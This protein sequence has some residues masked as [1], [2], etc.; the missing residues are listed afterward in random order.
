MPAP[1]GVASQEPGLLSSTRSTIAPDALDAATTA[2]TARPKNAGYV[3][4]AATNRSSFG[5]TPLAGFVAIILVSLVALVT[6]LFAH[7]ASPPR[8]PPGSLPPDA[9]GGGAGACRQSWMSPS[10]LHISGTSLPLFRL[11]S[12]RVPEAHARFFVPRSPSPSPAP[13]P[14]STAFGR[15]YSRLG[16]GPWGLY[17]Y[18]EEGWDDDPFEP[19]VGHGA[20]STDPTP[21]AF[22]LT[23]IPVIFVPGNAGS[24]RQ[25]RSLASA[26][27]RAYYELPGV[28]RK[29]IGSKEGGR[30]LDF[31]TLDF[32]DDFSA[33]HGQ[34]L[35]DQAEY[36]AD[37]IRYIL[38]LY[39]QESNAIQG[40]PDPTSVIVIGHSMGGIVARAALL[41][42]HYQSGSISTLVTIAT[43]HAVPPVTVDRGVDRVYDNI[44]SYW[45]RAHHL[46]AMSSP[47]SRRDLRGEAELSNLV[48]VSISGGI[49][50][51]TVASES[52]SLTSIMP[53]NDSHG[54]TVFTTAI[55]GVQTPIDHLAMLWCRQLVETVAT[56][57]LAIV[58]VRSP[59]GVLPR[60]ARVGK[61]AER[62]L[63]AIESH[64]VK[65]EGRKSTLE[66]L[67]RGQHGRE[68]A[69]G[70]RLSL[71]GHGDKRSTFVLPIPPRR[72]YGS[73]RVFSL[74]TSANIGRSLDSL[75]E[76]YAC[77]KNESAP[78]STRSSSCTSLFPSFVTTIPISPHSAQSPILPAPAEDGT[79]AFLNVDVSQLESQD[80]IVVVV[81]PGNAWLLAEFGDKDRRIHTVDKSA[82]Q[83]MLGGF[84]IENFPTTPSLISELWLPALDSSL[85]TFKMKVFRS[86][87][88][89]EHREY[90]MPAYFYHL[91]A[92]DPIRTLADS[93]T[94]LFAPLLRQYSSLLHESKY[95]PNVREAS[96]Y[97]HASGPYLPAPASPFVSSGARLQL[98]VDPT[99]ARE[100]S[101]A[102]ADVAIEIKLDLWASLGNLAMRYR[103]AVVAFPFALILLVFACQLRDYN[104]GHSF[105]PFA[106]A[107]GTFARHHLMPLLGGLVALS[108]LQSVMLGT[109]LSFVE[110]KLAS[111]DAHFLPS[112]PPR[113]ISEMLLGNQ[114]PFFAFLGAFILFTM[115]S[116]VVLEYAAL[117]LL[118]T[119]LARLVRL[120]RQRG[121]S[122][123]RSF[124]TLVEPRE[125]LP[126]QRIVTMGALGLLV[127]FFA[128]Y[129]FAFLV[130]FLVHLLS[131][132][133]ALLLAQDASAPS[134]PASTRRLWDRYH[135]SFVSLLV[136]IGL[137]PINAMILAVWVRNLAVGWLA[138]F[139]TDHNVLNILGFLLNV[140]AL[141]SGKML[142]RTPGPTAS[143]VSIALPLIAAGFA[144]LYG[145]R[146]TY[147][148]YPLANAFFLW[149]SSNH[150][151]HLVGALN[152]AVKA[153]RRL[154]IST[155]GQHVQSSSVKQ[156]SS[157]AL[158]PSPAPR[159]PTKR[160]FL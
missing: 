7:I 136:M 71:R 108:F 44:N 52:A 95:F 141:H 142:Q 15:E 107:L 105:P 94:V 76:V 56:A 145:I 3:V 153:K 118:V 35:L 131:T 48:L 36:L 74:L 144:L 82:F 137:L 40:R 19:H 103:M 20:A 86:D 38:S 96:L 89:G 1:A 157:S 26:A 72:T 21:R 24:F 129:Q 41:H 25:V 12:S 77:G 120:I 148:I 22:A 124:V 23:G 61:L 78:E 150:S 64:P 2:T 140:E 18:R 106:T 102:S 75:V 79:M 112:L 113:W 127:L 67:E 31:F 97:T 73:A 65:P 8:Y 92:T 119:V 134:T 154:S 60:E 143:T 101:R 83:L 30:P 66:S 151:H 45:R 84:K 138:P 139:S 132:V 158:S 128:P 28:R 14:D 43:P 70:E 68:L 54:F 51:T 159:T 27:S 111:A 17:L 32:N 33:F 99:C 85:L 117:Y 6:V 146:W 114:G 156:L 10:Y 110:A 147:N 80:L 81:K 57:L 63:G 42:P 115:L 152:E 4:H 122:Q 47:P 149:L 125:T 88:Q 87:C 49:S 53:L 130:L 100:N 37:S 126:L 155:A 69:I 160:Q 90:S 109:R 29:G 91:S 34:T 50:D 104:S 121:P 16:A 46:E 11:W 55:P 98:I 5:R 123:M 116:V 9:K 93:S 13:N 135:Y 39:H 59:L 58:D 133:R 62:L